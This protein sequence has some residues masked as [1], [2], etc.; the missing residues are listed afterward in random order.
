M[1]LAAALAAVFAAGALAP[2]AGA[3]PA[4]T[5]ERTIQDCDGDQM[6]EYAP[7]ERHAPFGVAGSETCQRDEAGRR[8]RLPPSA[9]IFNFL[10]LT[11]FQTVD[12]ESPARVEFVDGTQRFPGLQPFSAAYRPQESLSGHVTEA[13][14]RQVR[15]AVSPVT[16]RKPGLAI[17]TGDNADS[18]QYNET[19]W[20][21]DILDGTNA[22]PA[23]V[24]P[25]SGVPTNE[26]GPTPG[27]IY[28]GVRGGGVTGLPDDGYYEPDSSSG[29]R[30]DGDGYS[31][32]R[33][34][35]EAETPGRDVSVRDWPGLFE[36][37][38][39]PFEALGL[40]MPW[41]SAFGNHDA[42][43][44][45]NSPE[46]YAGPAGPGN[47]G[48]EPEA[49]EVFDIPFNLIATGCAKVRAPSET[50][51][52]D[53]EAKLAEIAEAAEQED[54]DRLT[55]EVLELAQD[56]CRT[57]PGDD[58]C[59]TDTVPPDPR[60]CF[61]AK[62][63]V[64]VGAPGTP[65]AIASWID[66]HFITTG[67][68]VGHGFANRPDEARRNNDGYYA[69]TPRPGLRFI[70]LD[71]VT[72]SCGSEFC[73]EGSVDDDQFQWLR[74]E[75]E[76]APG[77]VMVFAHH[78]LRTTRFPSDD[79]TEEPLH[80]GQRFDRRGGEP[81]RDDGGETLEELFCSDPAVL[82]YIAGHEHENYVERQDC[83]DDVPAVACPRGCANPHFWQVSTAAHVDWP[84]QA[85]MIELVDVGGEM[86]LVLTMLDHDGPARPGG[87]PEQ[88]EQGAAPE[89]VLALASIGREIAYNDYQGDR[90]ARGARTDR[91]VIL[92]TDR[93][94]PP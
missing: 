89:G 39:E 72:D 73:S 69:F 81:Q 50:V 57:D 52:D 60:R 15:N 40:D 31:P 34:D 63:E 14:V 55:G 21:I 22:S 51:Q 30:E 85:R 83:A 33:A 10:Q 37:A 38:N 49:T 35:N 7:G 87:R 5:V 44:Q 61:L 66:Q 8:L 88:F 62:D 4:T 58:P 71:T 3:A 75:I 84:Q 16:A 23:M 79:L 19:R 47:L 13:M 6:L 28:D 45:G 20:F 67:T 11:D 25:N 29:E 65:C 53:I 36:R 9:S 78:T 80:Y 68:P 27:S 59:V 76:A 64:K 48:E 2:A 91:N 18:Q 56:P 46:A 92:P 77:Y 1:R 70:V 42:L 26:C 86:S 43:V 90:G 17:L 94:P 12:E 82:A 74:R 24:D 32:L 54:V 93:P 41:Y